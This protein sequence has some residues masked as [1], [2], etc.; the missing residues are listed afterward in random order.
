MQIDK[1][2][3]MYYRNYDEMHISFDEGINVFIGDNA[4]GKTNLIESIYFLSYLKSF[5]A[6]KEKML[7]QSG[8]DKA[9]IGAHIISNSND[10][11]SEILLFENDKK[12]IKLN[13]Y[14]IDKKKEYIGQIHCVVFSPDD[15]KMI[16]EGP[17]ERR[18]F[19][20][21]MMIKFFP[22]Y[23]YYYKRYQHLLYQRNALLKRLRYGKDNLD[24][25]DVFD[26]QISEA[27]FEITRRRNEFIKDITPFFEEIYSHICDHKEKANIIYKPSLD[28]VQ[29][30]E[31][32][33]KRYKI[34]QNKQ[35]E[36]GQTPMGPQRDDIIFSINT[37]DSK[38]YA[39]QGQIR[40][41]ALALRLSEIFLI[42]ERFL[43]NPILL[44]D[45]VLSE[46]DEKR[47]YHL[48]YYFKDIQTLITTTDKYHLKNL[49]VN[50]FFNIE[51]GHCL[52]SKK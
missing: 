40:S 49:K 34:N 14:E 42:K 48:L 25:L 8:K 52:E 43:E 21:E 30:K 47:R 20:D 29:N 24:M 41:L 23:G 37:L 16:K 12:R 35:I 51:N 11:L 17:S 38:N 7:I 27:A 19:L 22:V 50:K 32:V 6:I 1:L 10:L 33:F 18:A 4:Q 46:L 9:Y 44:L 31:D 39:S 15:M 36:R 3:L 26:L 5:R 2:K 45:D 13:K 28:E